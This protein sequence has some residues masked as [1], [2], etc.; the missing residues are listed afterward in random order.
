MDSGT[1]SPV[2]PSP[3]CHERESHDRG[4]GTS[5]ESTMNPACPLSMGKV[6]SRRVAHQ[7]AVPGAGSCRQTPRVAE[8]RQRIE[9]ND[10]TGGGGRDN[11]MRLD[12]AS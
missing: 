6:P 4:P 3:Q 7:Y 12:Q 1:G 5:L 8:S 10:S 9:R 11:A 2:L